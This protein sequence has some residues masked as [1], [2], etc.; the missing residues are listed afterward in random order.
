MESM[1]DLDIVLNIMGNNAIDVWNNL[2]DTNLDLQYKN[3]VSELDLF[4]MIFSK[5]LQ[6]Q[7]SVEFLANGYYLNNHYLLSPDE[8]Y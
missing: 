5:V 2:V 3:K 8:Y 1:K 6:K 7:K 4:K